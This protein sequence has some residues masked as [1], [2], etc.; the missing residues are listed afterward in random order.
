MSLGC[1]A[2]IDIKEVFRRDVNAFASQGQIGLNEVSKDNPSAPQ[3]SPDPHVHCPASGSCSLIPLLLLP[4]IVF[5]PHP[6]NHSRGKVEHK[7][8]SFLVD[9]VFHAIY[10]DAQRV[11]F[12]FS[13]T[14]P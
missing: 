3:S 4:F 5:F 11:H 12:V 10:R 2:D 1:A 13:E 8:S 9:S 6:N 14:E 7:A